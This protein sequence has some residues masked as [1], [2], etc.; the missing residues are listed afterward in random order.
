M[1]PQRLLALGLAGAVLLS[2]CSKDSGTTPSNT[3]LVFVGTVNGDNGGLSGSVSFSITGTAVTGTFTII[4]PSASSH[5][6]T[7]TYNTGSKAMAAAGDGYN[8]AGV[9]DGSSRMEGGMT[10]TASGTFVTVKDNGN[11]AVAY[12]GSF[13]GDDDGVFNFT[14]ISGA[15]HG[16]ATTTSGTVI[17]L[18]GT[19]SSG[20]IAIPGL[21]VGTVSG[22]N[23]SGT[24][25]NGAGSSGTWTGAKCN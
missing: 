21:A 19:V 22:T 1:Q 16:T 14:V 25:D 12:C 5:A 23:V 17:A 2:A 3:T 4:A 8:F 11:T 7:G 20:N 10:G 18:D 6:L 24:W 15:L 13:T 9:Y